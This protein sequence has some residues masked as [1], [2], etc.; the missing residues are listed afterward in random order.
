MAARH[1]I[2]ADFPACA[3]MP[4][5]ELCRRFRVSNALIAR[6]RRE[7]GVYVPPGAPSGN[8]NSVGNRGRKKETH[9]IDNIEAV[10]ICLSCTRPRCTG[11]CELVR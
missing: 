10:K 11:Q 2:P 7:L 1:E 9:G 4:T 3:T 6:W 5:R 8:G